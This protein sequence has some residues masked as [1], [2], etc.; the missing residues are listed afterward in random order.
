MRFN[1][2]SSVMISI[3]AISSAVSA[4][5]TKT[6]RFSWWGPESRHVVTV[7]AIKEY[8]R[9]NPDVKI[10]G[11]YMDF[12]GYLERLVMQFSGGNEPDIMQVNWAWIETI[13][14][15][16]GGN[17][18][19]LYKSKKYLRLD[20]FEGK[21]KDGEIN[22]H[23]NALPVS[24]T[25]RTLLWQK[26]TFDKAGLR[27]PKTW[28]D[29][30]AAG[31]VFQKKLGKEYYPLSGATL[32][33]QLLLF[34]WAKQRFGKQMIDDN[35]RK[36][37]YSKP[38]MKELVL[39]YR[40]LKDGH[41]ISPPPEHT[42]QTFI[43]RDDSWVS[44][45]WA[46]GYKWE[47][48]ASIYINPLKGAAVEVGDF[49]KLPGVKQN[50]AYYHPAFMYAVS[51][52]CRYPDD[53]AK[54]LNFMLTDPFAVKVQGGTRGISA[55]RS[56]RNQ[57]IKDGSLSSVQIQVMNRMKADPPAK[58]SPWFEHIHVSEYIFRTLSSYDEGQ[59]NEDEA[60]RRL[61]DEQNR[62]LRTIR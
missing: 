1:I 33:V 2:L 41:V 8:E 21:E 24:Y 10:V 39:F 6:L 27:I 31:Q 42:D 44:G 12:G 53:A 58:H 56:A 25:I 51:T 34:C 32:D 43:G 40:K 62:I 54:F 49:P 59:I 30:I 35:T 28:D 57:Q 15:K 16:S 14:S 61:V 37:A 48:E 45:K 50:T 55:V 52:H 5:E 22:G 9:R 13:F 23:L 3:F 4:S 36:V 19:D 7:K 26:R 20:E 11:E 46:G 38:Q 17:F 60:A 18:Y 47:T 29:I